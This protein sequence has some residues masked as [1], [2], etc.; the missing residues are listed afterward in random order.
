MRNRTPFHWASL[1]VGV[2]L[3]ALAVVPAPG[4]ARASVEDGVA[5]LAAA[6]GGQAEV[7]MHRTTGAARFVRLPAGAL[8]SLDGATPEDRSAAF[9]ARYGSAFG[10]D[11]AAAELVLHSVQADAHRTHV[12]YRQV[13]RGV[14]VFGGELKAHFDAEGQLTV[15]NGTFAPGLA[16]DVRPVWSTDAAAGVAIRRVAGQESLSAKALDAVSSR[17]YVYRAGLL[18]GPVGGDH[19]VYEVE[20]ADAALTVRERVYVDAHSGKVVN[21]ITMIHHALD[22][23][24]YEGNL[25]NLV[26]SEGDPDPIPPGWAGGTPQQII[27]WQ[28]EIDGARETYNTM[29][30][31]TGGTYLSYDGMM[32]TMITVNNDP[33]INCPNANWNGVSTNYC[34]GVTGDD[35][36]AHEW[37]HAYTEYTNNLIY[38]WQSGALNEAYSDIWGEVVDLINARGTDA[39]GGPRSTGGCSIY[40]NGTPSVDN[41]YR[42]LSGEDDPAFGGAIRDMWHPNCYG[43]PGRVLDPIYWCTTGDFGGVHINSGIPN[44]AFALMV[45]GGTYNGQTVSGIGLTKASRIHWEAQNLLTISSE[46][47][48]HADALAA[49]CSGLIGATLYELDAQS[50]TGVVSAQVI[51]AADCA[52]VTTAIAAVELH[53]TPNCIWPPLLDPDAPTLCDGEGSVVSIDSED[54]ESGLGAWTVG[55][56]DVANPATFDT[57][58]W[59]VVTPLP[60]GEPGSAAFVADILLGDCVTD[61]EAGVLFL[62]SPVIN[63]PASAADARVAF[64]H[65]VATEL[66]WDGGNVKVSVNGGAFALVPGSAYTFNTYPGSLQAPPNDNPMAGEEA[67]TGTDEGTVNGSWG[68]SQLTLDGIAAPGDD[69]RIRFEFGVD[70]CNGVIGWYVDEVEVYTC[71]AVPSDCGNGLLDPGETCDDGNTVPGDGCSDTCQVEPGWECTDP[72][73]PTQPM[74]VVA[75]GSFEAGT[76][77]PSWA[78]ASTNFGSP[79]CSQGT[80]GGPPP[81][82]GTYHVWFGGI[83]AYEAGSVEQSAVIPATATTLD[84]DLTV[85]VCDSANDY[86]RV[87]LD[88]NQ[89]FT[90][91]PCTAGPAGTESVNIGAYADGAAHALRFESE[92]F[93]TNGSNSN[94]FLDNVVISDNLGDPGTPSICT[95][96]GCDPDNGPTWGK[97]NLPPTGGTTFGVSGI[98]ESPP[99]TQVY[100]FRAN[101]TDTG[102][103][104]TLVGTLHD[105]SVTPAYDVR[106]IYTDLPSTSPT[107]RRGSF[108]ARIF[109]V[110]SLTAVGKIAGRWADRPSVNSIGRYKGEWSICD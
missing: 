105:G 34:S 9:F 42:W 66:G 7:K 103:G 8:K 33:T 15:A 10:V 41:S 12:T 72:I 59:A 79:I 63:I 86:M 58:D 99:G 107:T 45:D 21:Q 70:G 17:L 27:D 4:Q 1:T 109:P 38:Q 28:D 2:L 54:W 96:V 44:H 18:G 92:T 25:S 53:A 85:G 35:T 14:P 19:L 60:D 55:T 13:H 69:I 37:G 57:P 98:L 88:G 46:F 84:F 82:D 39:P 56:R 97:W 104:G 108:R 65:W 26:W 52:E 29:G 81:S 22:R 75:D 31:M 30:S 61:L 68:Q 11:K 67:F 93:A 102:G 48:D 71:D 43:D 36:V 32:A 76:P 87:R 3:L 100:Y 74:N 95:E 73:P 20:V 106:G 5:R 16:V 23:E 47:P 6:T 83:P 110:G 49:A 24:V 91:D 90:T 78:E 40:G 50:P 89:V 94:F 101:L 64:D 51:S 77:N 80:C 62:E